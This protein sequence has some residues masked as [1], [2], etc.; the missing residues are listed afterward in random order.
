[1]ALARPKVALLVS[2]DPEENRPPLRF[3]SWD[4]NEKLENKF[5]KE[6][7]EMDLE[8]VVKAFATQ[9][10]L[11]SL[12]KDEDVKAIFWVG[13]A[14]FA[15]GA[16]GS[17]TS[18]IDYKNRNLEAVF[19]LI[20][21]HLKYLALVGCRGQKFIDLWKTKGWPELNS[22]LRTFAREKKTD[23]RV[24]LRKALDH[25]KD[26]LKNSDYMERETKLTCEK[27]K[28]FKVKATRLSQ[29]GNALSPILL[30]QKGRLANVN[31]ELETT[32]EELEL[33]LEPGITK[34]D[35][36]LILNTGYTSSL[37]KDYEIGE[38]QFEKEGL[39]K[40][41]AKKDGTPIGIGTRIYQFIGEPQFIENELEIEY[42]NVCKGD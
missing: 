37:P 11:Y 13:H 42:R 14:G 20:P 4:I 21:P 12:F 18:I 15:E 22:S 1:M 29:T 6:L 3:K 30:F 19:Q 10:T 23:A 2:L 28:F 36:K 39:W 31:T 35:Y 25:F 24:G 16:I 38:L 9:D 5:R 17:S 27:K 34:S 33:L 40:L 41:F 8:L 7:K 26:T 32:A